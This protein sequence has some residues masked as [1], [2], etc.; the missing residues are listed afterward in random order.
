M[1]NLILSNIKKSF[2]DIKTIH[3]VDFKIEDKEFIVFVGPSGCGKSTLLRLIAGLDEITSG[4]LHIGGEDVTNLEPAQRGISMVFQSYALYPHMNVYDNM[5]FGLKMNGFSKDEIE[6]RLQKALKIL[7]LENVAHYK[8]KSLSGGQRQRVAIG[9]SIVRN[10]KVFLLDEPLSNL[11][12]ELRSQM[13]I[14]LATLHKKLDT[15]MIYVT[16]DQTEAMTLAH[17]I[18]VLRAGLVEQIGTPIEVYNNPHNKF[19]ASFIGSPAINF[20]DATIIKSQKNKATISLKMN[21]EIIVEV[22]T[23]KPAPKAST[24]IFAGIRPEHFIHDENVQ[25]TFSSQISL[26]EQL[27]NRSYIYALVNNKKL[28]VEC[29]GHTLHKIGEKIKLGIDSSKILLFDENELRI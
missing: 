3:G 29:K 23:K 22:D 25:I 14:E 2:G 11:D 20:I 17:R 10:P 6:K 15:T 12:A 1:A 9:R 8:P 7:E 18:V 19:V 27:G 26:V 4:T 28:I 21:D 13:R 16:H 5:A 24:K